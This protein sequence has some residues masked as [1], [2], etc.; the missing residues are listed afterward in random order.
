MIRRNG[1]I[2][3]KIDRKTAKALHAQAKARGLSLKDYL[4]QLGAAGRNGKRTTGAISSSKELD[5]ALDAFF[6]KHAEKL[7]ALPKD[8]GRADIYNDHD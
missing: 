8:S 1:P 7:P 6:A 2:N 4:Q 5:D 3:V